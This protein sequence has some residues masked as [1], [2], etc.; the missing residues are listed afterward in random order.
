MI[1]PAKTR[2]SSAGRT[3]VSHI[4]SYHSVQYSRMTIQDD[5][6][7]EVGIM[8]TISCSL[9]QPVNS[10]RKKKMI[11]KNKNRI[12]AVILIASTVCALVFGLNVSKQTDSAP[13]ASDQVQAAET[14]QVK[15]P[16]VIY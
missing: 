7:T 14:K 6:R 9:R 8:N 12:P 15:E 2:F 10:V 16:L 11:M 5:R 4:H 13:A 3:C 1:L